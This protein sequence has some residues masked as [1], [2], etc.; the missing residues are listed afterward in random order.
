M[1]VSFPGNFPGIVQLF[2]IGSFLFSSVSGCNSYDIH[3][4]TY[5]YFFKIQLV[6]LQNDSRDI[7]SFC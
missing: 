6:K 3:R 4:M 1:T 2:D 5:F 7:S